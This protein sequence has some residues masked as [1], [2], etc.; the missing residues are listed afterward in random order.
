MTTK[1]AALGLGI[2]TAIAPTAALAGCVPAH[3]SA[4]YPTTT[5]PTS[6]PSATYPSPYPAT[7]YPTYPSYGA[8]VPAYSPTWTPTPLPRVAPPASRRTVL[9]KRADYDGDGGITFAEAQAYGRTEFGYAD[10]D[11]NGVLTRRE[12][13]NHVDEFARAARRRGRDDVVT[14][15][16]Y[17]RSVRNRF[18]DLDRNRDGFVSRHEVQRR[19]EPKTGGFS[20]HWQL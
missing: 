9:L 5:Y 1:L 17:D 15:A 16:E 4:S 14:F 20:W 12:L 10:V 2:A 18:M 3:P 6:D 8:P 7:T 13:D 11:R 19:P